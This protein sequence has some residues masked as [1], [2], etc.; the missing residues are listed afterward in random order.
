MGLGGNNN[1][2][3][4]F[5]DGRADVLADAID[6]EGIVFVELYEMFSARIVAVAVHRKHPCLLSVFSTDQQ[7]SQY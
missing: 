7:T 6:Q 2:N 1:P 3:V 4:S 5:G